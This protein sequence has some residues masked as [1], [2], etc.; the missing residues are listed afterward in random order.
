MDWDKEAKDLLDELVKPIP[1]FARPMA[2]KG[3]EKKNLRSC[4]RKRYKRSGCTRLFNCLSR[5]YAGTSCEAVT[6]KKI[7]IWHHMNNCCRS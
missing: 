7:L 4:R 6:G 5:K 1:I 2:R 3:I